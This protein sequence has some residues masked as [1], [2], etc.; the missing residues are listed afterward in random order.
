MRVRFRALITLD[1]ASARPEAREYLNY[2]H[3]IVVR[4][5]GESPGCIRSFPAEI[6]WDDDAVLHP[7]DHAVVTITLLD[8]QA[9]ALFDAG[10]KFTLWSSREI[11]HGVVS[12]RVVFEHAPS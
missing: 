1:P 12:R 6:C 3:A 10:R 4:I 7:G 11:G 9:D 2:T 5:R 8:E